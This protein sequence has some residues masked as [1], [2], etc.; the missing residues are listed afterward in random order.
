MKQAFVSG[1][2]KEVKEQQPET[3]FTPEI[4]EFGADAGVAER[5][6]ELVDRLVKNARDVQTK[7]EEGKTPDQGGVS[8]DKSTGS[9]YHRGNSVLVDQVDED[10]FSI[11]DKHTERAILFKW[12]KMDAAKTQLAP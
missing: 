1:G 11:T 12:K 9:L 8:R 7:M 10:S 2:I 5:R 6:R 4:K 3:P